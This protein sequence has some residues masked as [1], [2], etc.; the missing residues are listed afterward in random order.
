VS[1]LHF[2]INVKAVLKKK[3]HPQKRSENFQLDPSIN[4]NISDA[5]HVIL[6]HAGI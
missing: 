2:E 6:K 3:M 1:S 5:T 4:Y